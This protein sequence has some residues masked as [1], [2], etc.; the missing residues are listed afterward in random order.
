ME[1]AQARRSRRFHPDAQFL[2][3]DTLAKH[4]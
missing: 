2:P 1:P 4:A 3:D